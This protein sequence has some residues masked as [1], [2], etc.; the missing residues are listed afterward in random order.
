[1]FDGTLELRREEGLIA[2][3]VGAMFAHLGSP[4]AIGP[5]TRNGPVALAGPWDRWPPTRE[6]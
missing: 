5:G 3:E 1:V 2:W 6:H 4:P